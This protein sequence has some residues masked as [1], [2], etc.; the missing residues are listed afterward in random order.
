MRT[1]N[2]DCEFDSGRIDA[3]ED[4]MRVVRNKL[5]SKI[6]V[7]GKQY[8]Y[9]FSEG[10]IIFRGLQFNSRKELRKH[11]LKEIKKEVNH[12]QS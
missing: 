10:I 8:Q 4:N 6:K 5:F 3:I 2:F 9:L 12:A 11:I 1:Y 7:A